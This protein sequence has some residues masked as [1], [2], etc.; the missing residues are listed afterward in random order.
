MYILVWPVCENIIMRMMTRGETT[1][2]AP[3]E[4]AQC[5]NLSGKRTLV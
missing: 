3:K 5:V 2:V 4:Q 1:N